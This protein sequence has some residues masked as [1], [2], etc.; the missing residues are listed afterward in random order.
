MCV[1]VSCAHACVCRVH[2]HIQ[3]QTYC[4]GAWELLWEYADTHTQTHTHTQPRHIPPPSTP[5]LP[6]VVC[7]LCVEEKTDVHFLVQEHTHQTIRMRTIIYT[8]THARAHTHI[9]THKQT[10]TQTYTH[11]LLL[12]FVR[13]QVFL[14]SADDGKAVCITLTTITINTTS[15]AYIHVHSLLLPFVRLQVFLP[16]AE[17]QHKA[18]S[19]VLAGPV[20]LQPQNA[21]NDNLWLHDT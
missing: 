20:L 4:Q 11:S 7:L 2:Q 1:C 19:L 14:P 8:H 17:V 12:P 3:P 10:H 6:F 21:R 13:L 18:T 5:L 16:S 9:H 15:H